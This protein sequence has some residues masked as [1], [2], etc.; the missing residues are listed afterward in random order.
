MLRYLR[1]AFFLRIPV[2]GLGELP[3]NLL[4][5]ICVVILGFPRPELWL[6]GAGLELSYLTI[7]AT[8]GRF[9]RLINAQRNRTTVQDIEAKRQA[10]I[11]DLSSAARQ[12]LTQMEGR[13]NRILD[14]YRSFQIDPAVVDN[15]LD[16]FR[17]LQW[18][19]L[20]LLVAQR[21]L[22]SPE[23]Q[24]KEEDLKA[25]ITSLEQE[26]ASEKLSDSMRESKSATLEIYR[27]RL[28]NLQRRE[29]SLQEIDAD[30]ARIEAQVDLA[31]ENATM[32]GQPQAISTNIDLVSHLLD[33]AVYG[34][35]QSTIADLEPTLGH[36]TGKTAQAQ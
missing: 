5:L 30:M 17:Y 25:K 3:L 28:E 26:V 1:E 13:C 19:Y 24:V 33:D 32:K 34:Q 18:L 29:Q 36:S 12:R 23:S 10:L 8:N 14:L 31:M 2:P 22:L 20:K 4:A 16:V 6:L 27:K 11:A 15:N 7:L 21:Y 9:Q 35:S